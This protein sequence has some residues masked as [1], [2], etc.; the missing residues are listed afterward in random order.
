MAEPCFSLRRLISLNTISDEDL[1]LG[2][3]KVSATTSMSSMSSLPLNF[4][5]RRRGGQ[6]V[7]IVTLACGT[8]A[9]PSL[10]CVMYA[11]AVVHVI[12]RHRETSCCMVEAT[13]LFSACRAR[14]VDRLC[15]HCCPTSPSRRCSLLS[16][17]SPRY[18]T[19]AAT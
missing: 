14:D 19:A 6:P 15:P 1:A 11:R 17:L 10:R 9:C 4:R 13:L 3:I 16:T 7:K 2:G 18:R 8:G 12:S 5:M